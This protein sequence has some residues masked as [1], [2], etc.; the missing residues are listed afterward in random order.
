MRPLEHVPLGWSCRI[1]HCTLCLRVAV[2][3]PMCMRDSCLFTSFCLILKC[4]FLETFFEI[5]SRS[6][7]NLPTEATAA[8]KLIPTICSA[9][10]SA[11]EEPILLRAWVAARQIMQPAY[12]LSLSLALSF[13]IFIFHTLHTS[14]Y[15]R[16]GKGAPNGIYLQS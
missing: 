5:G 3:G 10:D 8:L 15:R 11:A 4:M 14:T 2:R 16:T 12:S 6:N 7:L 13:S 1:S 9:S